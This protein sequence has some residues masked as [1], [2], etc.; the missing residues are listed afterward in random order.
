[1]IWVWISILILL[2]CICAMKV[3]VIV[4]YALINQKQSL[5]LIIKI[6]SLKIYTYNMPQNKAEVKTE[7]EATAVANESKS[8]KLNFLTL[9]I[10]FQKIKEWETYILRFHKLIRPKFKNVTVHKFQWNTECGLG[11]AAITAQAIG[12]LW[13]AK[14]M[15]AGLLS[16]YLTVPALPELRVAP[17][18]QHQLTQTQF[19][20]MFS[21]RIGHAIRA[22]ISVLLHWR[23]RPI[24]KTRSEK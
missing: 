23:K 17:I 22:G 10:A 1:M 16:V 3:N 8:K 15:L 7:R 21:F 13:T 24:S 12:Y 6:F 18:Y 14:S 4:N 2:I 19:N 9:L 11:D 5:T 20:C